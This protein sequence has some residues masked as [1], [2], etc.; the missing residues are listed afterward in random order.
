MELSDINLMDFGGFA[1]DAQLDWFAHLRK[2]A[3]VWRHPDPTS[4]TGLGPWVLSKHADILRASKDPARFSADRDNGGIT[5]FSHAECEMI[6]ASNATE[7]M[8]VMMDPPEHTPFRQLVQKGFSRSRVAGLYEE[9][10]RSVVNRV[11]DAAIAKG[12]VDFVADVAVEL[13]LQVVAEVIGVPEE[14][15]AWLFDV[16]NVT[17]NA[18]DL[19]Y[20]GRNVE[21]VI[22]S[23]T[24]LK[25]FGHELIED[26]KTC[27]RDDLMSLVARA[28]IGGEPLTD[29]QRLSYFELFWGAGSETTRT[30]IAQA[31]QAFLANPEEYQKV[32]ED[33]SLLAGSAT[34]EMLRYASPVMWFKRTALED[35]EIRGQ[36]IAKG[37]PVSMWYISANYD[38]DVF[39]DPSTFDVLRSPNPH[40]TFGGGGPHHCM[41]SYLSRLEIRILFEELV[42]R[43]PNPRAAGELTRLRHN[44][45][46][47]I[48]QMPVD[49][50]SGRTAVRV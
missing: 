44:F 1:R 25:Q 37:D 9:H 36:H 6:S 19:E 12:T 16:V 30:T 29:G 43:V 31:M 21:Q 46:H 27:P 26:R 7:K 22:S 32:R 39:D 33:P 40:L 8:F 34:E 35:V 47:G 28:E 48:E 23:F 17:G 18:L 3:P 13:P 24:K 2:H 10:I 38:E 5:G 15:R 42:A 14:D 20:V 50:T 45:F 41:G 11:L 49:L 4:P